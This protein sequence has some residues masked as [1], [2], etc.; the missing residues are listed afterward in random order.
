MVVS[1]LIGK[2][3]IENYYRGNGDELYQCVDGSYLVMII[4][5]GILVVDN[6]NFLWQGF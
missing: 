1:K 2:C 5:Q 3:V 4:D 6:Q